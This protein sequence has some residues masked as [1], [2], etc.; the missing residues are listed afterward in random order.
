[1]T[2]SQDKIRSKFKACGLK[3]TPQRAAIYKALAETT[4]H[5]TAETLFQQVSQEYPM[6]SLNTVYYTLS[7]LKDAGL[8]KEVNY[9]HDG[10]RFDANVAQHHHLICLGCRAIFDIE[11]RVLNQI[12]YKAKLP[13]YFQVLSHQVDFYGCCKSCQKVKA[14]K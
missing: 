1:M 14:S 8:L 3:V 7:T 9:W 4:K 12:P 5:P 6:I 10:A 13:K 2:I 11:D